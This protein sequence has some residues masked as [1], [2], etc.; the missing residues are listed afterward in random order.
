[1]KLKLE[2]IVNSTD[3]LKALL[4]VKLPVKVSY[5]IKR[6]VDKINPIL[7]TFEA[8]RNDLIKEYG[9]EN[10]DGSM[11]VKDSEKINTYFEKLKEL[12]L[13]EEEIDWLG[14]ISLTELGDIALE[15]K[16]IVSWIFAE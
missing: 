3:Q 5:S 16:N 8:K 2:E 9:D 4:D 12:L 13:V 1:M 14:P 6:L 11:Q 15:P 7:T 10:E